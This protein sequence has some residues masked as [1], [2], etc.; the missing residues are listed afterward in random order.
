M[1]FFE[2]IQ[3]LFHL[4]GSFFIDIFMN[5]LLWFFIF[6][7]AIYYFFGGKNTL[8]YTIV[9]TLNIFAFLDLETTS[10]IAITSAGF[11]ILFYLTKLALMLFT[12]NSKSM[13][14]YIVIIST[15]SGYTVLI[16]YNFFLS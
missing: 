3:A 8:F 2:V 10:G 9:L 6:Y 12:E 11:L 13:Q 16:L 15:I 4:D 7:S 14:K 1:A 5:N